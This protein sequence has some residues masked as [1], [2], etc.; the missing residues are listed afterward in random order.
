MYRYFYVERNNLFLKD[1]CLILLSIMVHVFALGL[2]YKNFKEKKINFKEV[3]ISE[4]EFYQIHKAP[5]FP[6]KAKPM[7]K[8]E[9]QSN[10]KNKTREINKK[11]KKTIN[12]ETGK[13]SFSKIPSKGKKEINIKEKKEIVSALSSKMG[14]KEMEFDKNIK[15]SDVS[16]EKKVDKTIE[17][18][19][20]EYVLTRDDIM[21]L[22][23][24]EEVGDRKVSKRTLE[25]VNELE[26]NIKIKN[27][28]KQD[29]KP[30][31][32]YKDKKINKLDKEILNL[33]IDAEIK[34]DNKSIYNKKQID[35]DLDADVKNKNSMNVA[36]K[37]IVLIKD[38]G[39]Y[40]IKNMNADFEPI[41][42]INKQKKIKD[43]NDDIVQDIK[44]EQKVHKTGSNHKD[45]NIIGE[46]NSNVYEITG[47]IKNRKIL[48][49]NIPKYPAWAEEEGIEATVCVFLKVD[50]YGY[51]LEDSIKIDI[52]SGYKK[53]DDYVISVLKDW[54]FSSINKKE[55]QSGIIKFRFKLS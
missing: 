48:Y 53:L 13:K 5:I 12:N 8:I 2:I 40:D 11:R 46:K 43:F 35:I 10:L 14:V 7:K 21:D 29:F 6:V 38:K 42:I 27:F 18:K 15:V 32:L 54:R 51:V 44:K 36:K 20:K 49:S 52:T 3:T 41:K 37:D 39:S 19:D 25:I 55:N 24:L 34:L 47:S 17:L 9:V 50:M 1:F 23:N 33:D 30:V 31:D 4:V 22:V 28:N 16:L 26:N 45:I